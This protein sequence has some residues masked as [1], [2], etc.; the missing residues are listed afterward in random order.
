MNEN[1][2]IVYKMT[3]IKNGKVYIGQTRKRLKDRFWAHIKFAHRKDRLKTL[4]H[5][6]I[7]EYGKE[8]FKMKE[9]CKCKT[10][11]NLDL[12]EIYYIKRFKKMLGEN[13]Y[14]IRIGNSISQET[15]EKISKSKKGTIAWNKDKRCPQLAGENNGMFGKRGL[16]KT[17]HKIKMYN[18]KIEKIFNGS[19]EA[20]DFLKSIGYDKATNTTIIANCKGKRKSAYGYKWEYV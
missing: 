8:V 11:E 13:C 10:K 12:I 6:E 1:Y 2:G 17:T 3:N 16:Q 14:N 5:D 7:N 15:R 4:L 18:N 19:G 9:L 20:V